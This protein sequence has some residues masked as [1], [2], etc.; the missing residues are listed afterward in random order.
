M[1]INKISGVSTVGGGS[2][3][4]LVM[5]GVIT[6]NGDIHAQSA[7]ID[8]VITVKGMVETKEDIVLG[9][10]PTI[11]G[12]VK[13]RDVRMDGTCTIRGEVTGKNIHVDG[14]CMIQG[15]VRG[16]EIRVGGTCTIRENVEADHVFCKGVITVGGQ[17]SADLVEGRGLLNAKE[18]VGEKV[19][20]HCDTKKYSIFFVRNHELCKIGMIEAT[21]IDIDGIEAKAVN[22]HNVIIGPNCI[23]ENVDCSGT[24]SIAEGAEVKNVNGQPR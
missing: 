24:L 14:T 20:V 1:A 6:C 5:N 21:E 10:V 17:I 11:Q 12:E 2:Y 9:G 19:N 3:D 8:G 7:V 16:E 23:V 13:G 18:I 15:R 4:E 22:G